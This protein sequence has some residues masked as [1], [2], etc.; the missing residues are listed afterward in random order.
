M[1]S[2]NETETHPHPLAQEAADHLFAAVKADLRGDGE[3][4]D[5]ERA[6]SKAALDQLDALRRTQSEEK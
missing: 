5:A 6:S 1:K 2:K 3:R 4:A